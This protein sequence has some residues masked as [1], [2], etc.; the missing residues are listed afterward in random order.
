MSQNSTPQRLVALGADEA[1]IL[2]QLGVWPQVVGVTA[3]YKPPPGADEKPRVSGFSSG[4][5]EAIL[6]L[7][8]D[9]VITSTDVQHQLASDLIKAGV[10]VW[11]INSRSL[12]DIYDAIR[13]LG[14]I[15]R[16]GGR[17]EELVAQ[18]ERALQPVPANGAHR[19]RVYFEEW[20]EPLITGIGWVSELIERAGGA[21]T[22]GP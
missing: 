5:I 4:N 8:P 19:P 13:N 3:F 21:D 6:K 2:C 14:Q 15:V 20:P 22:L 16:K 10:T 12:E 1:D 7:Q 9:L 18:M 17:A 11:A